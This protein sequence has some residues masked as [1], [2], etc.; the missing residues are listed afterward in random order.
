LDE[1]FLLFEVGFLSDE[2][3]R[4]ASDFVDEVLDEAWVGW[5][6]RWKNGRRV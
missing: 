1:G 4:K 6:W 2:F 3:G 5:K